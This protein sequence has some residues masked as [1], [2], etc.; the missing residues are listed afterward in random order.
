MEGLIDRL[1]SGD[2]EVQRLLERADFYLVPNMNPDGAFHGHLRT[3]AAGK[4]LNRAW[5]APSAEESPEVL[6]VQEQMAKYG[7]D[8]FLDVHGD[9]E[10]PFVFAAGCEGN[11]EFTP[12]LDRLESLFRER[13]EA[14]GEFQSV[15]GY[16]KDAPGQANLTLACN[17]VGR[18]YDCLSLTLEMPFKDHNLSPNPRTGWSGGAVEGA[19]GGSAGHGRQPGRR[20]A[21]IRERR[22]IAVCDVRPGALRRAEGDAQFLLANRTSRRA[23]GCSR[24]SS[25]LQKS[26]F[27]GDVLH[28][29]R[30]T[31][32]VIR[33]A[34]LLN[35]PPRVLI[36]S[37]RHTHSG[38]RYD[39]TSQ[40]VDPASHRR[41]AGPHGRPGRTGF[42]RA[43]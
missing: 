5:A 14:N 9:E 28:P 18:T 34:W 24:A 8:L 42:Q 35:L 7:V 17:H 11:P 27:P 16:P 21:L 19:R 20:I 40:A 37:M 6:F 33:P 30:L 26:A 22:D 29:W 32:G 13:L 25:L 12:R 15:H 2:A 10:I 4:D 39:S 43:P 23:A 38:G 41:P 3:N 1:Q 36:Q 31:V